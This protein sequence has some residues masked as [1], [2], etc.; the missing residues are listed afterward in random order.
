VRVRVRVLALVLVRVRARVS[1][2]VFVF[3]CVQIKF[4][5]QVPSGQVYK[6]KVWEWLRGQQSSVP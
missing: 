6:R 3:M 2:R 1:V 5:A 4:V